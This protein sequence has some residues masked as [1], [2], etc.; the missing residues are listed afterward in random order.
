MEWKILARFVVQTPHRVIR[1]GC[2]VVEGDRIVDVGRAGL[3]GRYPRYERVDA[4]DCVVIPGLINAHCHAAMTLMRGIADDMPLDRWL[5]KIWS[6]ESELRREDVYVGTVIACLEMVRSGTT[7]F[8]DMYFYPGA[9]AEAVEEVGMRGVISVPII[10]LDDRARGERLLREGEEAVREHHG[11]AGGR[12]RCSFGPHAP[13]TCGPELLVR[14][15]E[16]AD[17]YHVGVHIHMAETRDEAKR[18]DEAYDLGL[19]G[20]SLVEYLDE[21]GFLGD[22]VIAAHCIWVT[23]RDIDILARRGVGVASNPV[24][25]MKLADGIAPVPEML[26]RGVGVGLGTDGAASNNCLD[27]FEEMKAAALLYKATRGD[28][29]LITAHQALEMATLGAARALRLEGLGAVEGGRK[30][31]LVLVDL[32]RPRLVPTHD[33]ISHLVYAVKGGDVKTVMIDGRLVYDRGRILTVDEEGF[34]ERA[35]RASES[36]MER[37]GV[38]G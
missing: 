28:P 32:K 20:R 19:N 2:V 25:N 26:N 36:L 18:A 21:I 9:V 35:Q 29:T 22:N 27:L 33:P 5:G 1:N 7:C 16:L 3:S 6:I 10:E 4:Q 23:D 38:G 34:L 30:A 17:R 15:R 11:R 14:A 37:A 8:N 13:Y 24:S 12:V 31:D